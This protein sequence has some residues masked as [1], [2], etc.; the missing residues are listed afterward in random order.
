MLTFRVESS[1][2]LKV[3][4][5][6]ALATAVRLSTSATSERGDSEELRMCR[7]GCCVECC[8]CCFAEPEAQLLAYDDKLCGRSDDNRA[9][10][11]VEVV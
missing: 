3:A 1:P 10:M 4:Q 7:D 6:W 11:R 9:M 5:T 2:V 8:C